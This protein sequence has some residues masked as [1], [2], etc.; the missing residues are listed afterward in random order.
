M[1]RA[2]SL[3]AASFAALAALCAASPASA[4]G[5]E[6]GV[7]GGTGTAM[8]TDSSIEP[9]VSPF[10]VG[11]AVRLGLGV[12][13]LEADA[14]WHR[15]EW[16]GP[17]GVHTTV[18]RVALPVLAKLDF[19]MVPGVVSLGFGAGIEPRWLV[20][21]EAAGQDVGGSFADQTL[22]LPV[23]AGV[24]LDL[25]VATA[26]LEIRYAHQLEPE[27]AVGQARKHELMLMM[28]LFF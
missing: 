14:L 7:R 1:H 17:T 22:F 15:A 21:A 5:L 6:W 9:E 16:A 13:S 2:H 26:N 10:T 19:P 27:G 12:I 20:G 8:W 11:P 3:T 4:L 28:G 25:Q 24:D 18:D 23:A